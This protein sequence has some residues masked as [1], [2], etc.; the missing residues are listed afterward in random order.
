MRSSSRFSYVA[1]LVL[2]AVLH[3][4]ARADMISWSYSGGGRAV[5]NTGENDFIPSPSG[6]GNINF[7]AGIVLTTPATGNNVYLGSATVPVVNLFSFN[8]HEQGPLVLPFVNA[9]YVADV[10][11]IDKASGKSNFV[12]FRG[13]LNGTLNE[14]THISTLTT[15]FVGPTTQILTLGANRYT[16]AIGPSEPLTWREFGDPGSGQ[17]GFG[18]PLDA[19]IDVSPANASATPE[20]S[21]MVL[22][23]M[24]LVTVAGAAWRKRRRKAGTVAAP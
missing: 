7:T 10:T 20:P 14:I 9:P 2:A 3:I 12:E 16:I 18:G 4:Q 8:S 5:T 6:L 23:G 22:A 19:H 11:I 21:C 13:I 24:G 1:A 17:F 15:S